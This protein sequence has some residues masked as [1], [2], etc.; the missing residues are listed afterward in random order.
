MKKRVIGITAL[1]AI[2][3]LVVTGLLWYMGRRNASVE[4][5][6]D[7][8]VAINELEELVRSGDESAFYEKADLLQEELRNEEEVVYQNRSLFILCGIC[9]LFLFVVFGYVYVAILRPFDKM[10]GFAEQI[11]QGNF[12]VPLNYERSNYFGAFT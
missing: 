10:K 5:R 6:R 4:D 1:F 11:A 2:V 12:E 7:R 8:V 3:I 9:I